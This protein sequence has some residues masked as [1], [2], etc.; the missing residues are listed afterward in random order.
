MEAPT[1]ATFVSFQ[2]ILQHRVRLL[3]EPELSQSFT[4]SELGLDVSLILRENLSEWLEGQRRFRSAWLIRTKQ[5][6]KEG[7][8]EN[9]TRVW[10]RTLSAVSI[11]LCHFPC[12]I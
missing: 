9:E 8:F 3:K 1:W 4:F 12:L 7:G 10:V 6:N 2:Q 5:A 11:A